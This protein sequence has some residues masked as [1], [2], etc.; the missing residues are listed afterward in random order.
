[1]FCDYE[2]PLQDL[3]PEAVSSQKCHMNMGQILNCYGDT[4]ICNAFI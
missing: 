3:I 2:S 1:M 4:V